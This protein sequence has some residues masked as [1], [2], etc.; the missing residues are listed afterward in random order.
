MNSNLSRALIV[1]AVS[2]AAL[3]ACEPQTQPVSDF[4]PPS[5]DAARGREVFIEYACY[6]CHTIPDV[7]LPEREAEPPMVFSLGLRLH[8]VRSY[9]ELLTAVLDPDHAV[10][11]KFV[12]ALKA[13][14][15][16]P[17]AA[18]MP[19][20]TEEMTVAELVDV[21]EFLDKE[22]SRLLGTQY[23]GK[24]P[25]RGGRLRGIGEE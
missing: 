3:T 24:A 12:S 17:A 21:V 5:G 19:D 15:E 9:G 10:S 4:M 7:D 18:Q 11:P 22:Y 25:R 6:N 20:F 2:M 1:V 14:G 8:R 13:A 16:D 23:K